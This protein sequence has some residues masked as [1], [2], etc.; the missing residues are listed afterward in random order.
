MYI[1]FKMA[2]PS[3]KRL[4]SP[5][6]FR[7]SSLIFVTFC[8]YIVARIAEKWEKAGRKGYQGVI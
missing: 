1:H 7:E 2:R 5:E 8:L 3:L 6:T 4:A